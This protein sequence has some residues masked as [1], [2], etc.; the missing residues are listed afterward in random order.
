MFFIPKKIN[1]INLNLNTLT[2]LLEHDLFSRGYISHFGDWPYP[3]YLQRTV[4]MS[5]GFDFSVTHGFRH[6]KGAP[7]Q[8]KTVWSWVHFTDR[9]PSFDSRGMSFFIFY[10]IYVFFSSPLCEM[11]PLVCFILLLTT[12]DEL[13]GGRLYC[14]LHLSLHPLSFPSP[15][16]CLPPH[17]QPSTMA[18]SLILPLGLFL[19]CSLAAVHCDH[20]RIWGLSAI[21]LHGDTFSQPDPY[22]KVWCGPDFGGTT[23]SMKDNANPNWGTQFNFLEVLPDSVLKLEVWDKDVNPDD[24]L[25]TCNTTIQ[26]GT[27]TITCH[28]KYGTLYYTY[29]Y[30]YG[31]QQDDLQPWTPAL[32][33]EE[34]E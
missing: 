25:G 16:A 30:G 33:V 27:Y 13:T 18:S 29:S 17:Q 4:N 21:N 5:D 6:Y 28:L 20:V 12:S 26:H 1:E 8:A 10:M 2:H 14:T 15:L 23:D 31:D 34:A 19:L 32:I 22:V 7:C 3:G 9:H 24:R 11:W